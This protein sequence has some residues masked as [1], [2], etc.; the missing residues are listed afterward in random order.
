M[1]RDT[2]KQNDQDKADKTTARP[3]EKA[4]M[5][6][7]TR[8]DHYQENLDEAVEETFPASDPISPSV[9]ERQERKAAEAREAAE[10]KSAQD[11]GTQKK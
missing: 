5:H 6:Q 7:G 4:D 1:T 2:Q 11:K 8:D 10:R 9:A 3:Q